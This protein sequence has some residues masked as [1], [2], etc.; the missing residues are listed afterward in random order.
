MLRIHS[1]A[2]WRAENDTRSQRTT[3]CACKKARGG[4]GSGWTRKTR[5]T[6]RLEVLRRGMRRIRAFMDL[7][8]RTRTRMNLNLK[9]SLRTE[10]G[11]RRKAQETRATFRSVPRRQYP[12]LRWTRTRTRAAALDLPASPSS[13]ELRIP[14]HKLPHQH[15]ASL[16][17]RATSPWASRPSSS[18]RSQRWPS[19]P[20]PRSKPHAYPRS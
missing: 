4:S 10:K 2:T 17:R 5:K 11:R 14:H 1:Q 9:R 18:P 20:Q 6:S 15:A 16:Y 13:R 12:S 7:V 3:L 19:G 8:T